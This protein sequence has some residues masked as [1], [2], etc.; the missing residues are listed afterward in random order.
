MNPRIPLNGTFE[1]TARCNLHCKMCLIRQEPGHAGKREKTA[2]EWIDMAKQAFDAGT[3]SLLLTGGEIM[4]RHD[5][6]E[7]Y[8]E[9]AR[10]GFILTVYTN[11]TMVSEPVMEVF[12]RYPPHKIGVTVYGASNETYAAVTGAADGFDR[13]EHGVSQLMELPS[14]FDI[15]TTLIRENVNDLA[16]LREWVA[17]RFGKEKLLHISRYVIKAIRGGVSSPECCRLG[18]EENTKMLYSSEVALLEEIKEREGSLPLP[19]PQMQA[20]HYSLPPEGSY[21]FS[22]CRSGMHSYTLTWDGEMIAC[23]LL[24]SG[25]TKPFETG[26]EKAWE[27][28]PD[29]YPKMR[30]IKECN[31]CRYLYDCI[32]CPA[33]RK[34]ETGDWFGIP[35]YACEDAKATHEFMQKL[36]FYQD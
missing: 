33:I 27:M 19:E 28:L 29:C 9:I 18:A 7:L 30:G 36:G 14:Q 32:Q 23:E 5:F 17:E 25:G 16:A 6:C 35:K 22:G 4:L 10:M 34:A 24:G 1:L 2:A 15:R 31:D 13:L 11:A 26:F 21:L 3:I 8:E 12:R 20:Q